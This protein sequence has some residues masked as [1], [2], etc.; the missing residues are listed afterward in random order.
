ME[1]ALVYSEPVSPCTAAVTVVRISVPHSLLSLSSSFY[2]CSK[3]CIAAATMPKIIR[4]ITPI[5]I[6]RVEVPDLTTTTCDQAKVLIHAALGVSC[7]ADK[8]ICL[9]AEP[10]AAV[11]AFLDR[12]CDQFVSGEA[13]TLESVGVVKNGQKVWV[14]FPKGSGPKVPEGPAKP[15]AEQKRGGLDGLRDLMAGAMGGGGGGGG[16]GRREEQAGNR[17]GSGNMYRPMKDPSICPPS[18]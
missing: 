1:N 14:R 9:L 15:Q 6:N 3:D 18:G 16:G 4:I 2:L 10:D 13:A 17:G 5:G 12:S 11:V 8:L 7:S